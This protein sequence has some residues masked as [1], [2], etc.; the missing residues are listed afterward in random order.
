MSENPCHDIYADAPIP[1][2]LGY[3]NRFESIIFIT[4]SFLVI[5]SL[6]PVLNHSCISTDNISNILFKLLRNFHSHWF[7]IIW[8][9]MWHSPCTKFFH[10]KFL[11]SSLPIPCIQFLS[12]YCRISF[13]MALTKILS[14]H[15]FWH[16]P[17]FKTCITIKFKLVLN[18]E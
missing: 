17:F 8:K 5:I 18:T 3:Y 6:N 9:Q 4:V 16:C 13:P 14:L 15:N 10:L 1:P 2:S 7:L 11:I 12:I